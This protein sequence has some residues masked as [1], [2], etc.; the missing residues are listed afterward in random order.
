MVAS[1]LLARLIL[2]RTTEAA[3][4]AEDMAVEEFKQHAHLHLP[5]S[6]MGQTSDFTGG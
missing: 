6:I 1:S 5:S 4:A 3:L 2:G